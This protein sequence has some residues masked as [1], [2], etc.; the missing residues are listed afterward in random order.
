MVQMM[1]VIEVHL[2]SL[3][4]VSGCNEPDWYAIL[5]LDASADETAVKKQYRKLALSLHPD[6]NKLYGAESAFK[7]IGEAS[8]ILSDKMKRLVYD[9][10]RGLSRKKPLSPSESHNVDI[11]L[12]Q[13]QKKQKVAPRQTGPEF[14]PFAFWT[15]CPYCKMRY[16]Y[17][18]KFEAKNLLCINCRR[19]FIAVDLHRVSSTHIPF[20]CAGKPHKPSTGLNSF[21]N[22]G[23]D[24]MHPRNSAVSGS[25]VKLGSDSATDG[26]HRSKQSVGPGADVREVPHEFDR[27]KG[28][29]GMQSEAKFP[30]KKD[31]GRDVSKNVEESFGSTNLQGEKQEAQNSAKVLQKEKLKEHFHQA[32]HGNFNSLGVDNEQSARKTGEKTA[33]EDAVENEPRKIAQEP[34]KS[35]DSD[36]E[37][38]GKS[39]VATE[40]DGPHEMVHDIFNDMDIGNEQ[41]VKQNITEPRRKNELHRKMDD[42]S[43]SMVGEERRERQNEE[44]MQQMNITKLAT[45]SQNQ[46]SLENREQQGREQAEEVQESEKVQKLH[47][48]TQ[49]KKLERQNEDATITN[50]SVESENLPNTEVRAGSFK[51]KQ[52]SS[53]KAVKRR[54]KKPCY[55]SDVRNNDN[56]GR[57][58]ITTDQKTGGPSRRS[59]RSKCNVI[60]VHSDTDDDFQYAAPTKKSNVQDILQ[61]DEVIEILSTPPKNADFARQ[62]AETGLHSDKRTI[63]RDEVEK[64]EE[65][66]TQNS[67]KA[68]EDE[69]TIEHAAAGQSFK[70]PDAEFFNFDE[71]REEKDVKVGQVWA[72]YDDTD[73]LPRYYMKVK[74]LQ[75]R[76]P[77]KVSVVWLELRSP[78]KDLHELLDSGY[79]VTCGEFKMTYTQVMRSVNSF[80]H[81]VMWEKAGRNSMKIYPKKGQV[82]CL[83]EDWKGQ[84]TRTNKATPLSY[85]MAEVVTDCDEMSGVNVILLRKMEGFKVLFEGSSDILAIPFPEILRFSHQVPAYKVTGNEA[86]N[87]PKG[88]WELDPAAVPASLM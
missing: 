35:T 74:A 21:A 80:S 44:H 61:S 83:Y 46:S 28:F 9:A 58:D 60:Y 23:H 72:L 69:R 64:E 15:S 3:S 40:K 53:P 76:Y 10:K 11:H 59:T 42:L 26:A 51:R 27:P 18:R 62:D 20:S 24:F 67:E 2:A 39:N 88:C 8:Q 66:E 52:E 38:Q 43:K 86:L 78:C 22:G 34:L 82:W 36:R 68:F 31:L 29:Q 41:R 1:A 70:I 65:R 47:R 63:F 37:K 6:K 48:S 45:I 32:P 50:V 75:S 57:G 13:K 85:R 55:S 25:T 33:K 4:K 12:P 54:R 73:G 71:G 87:V 30:H 79:S 56:D 49:T 17:L 81:L 84:L 14:H 5:Q 16:Q 19:P 77:F 7:L